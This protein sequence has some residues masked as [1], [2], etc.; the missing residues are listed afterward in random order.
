MNITLFFL[1]N[2]AELGEGQV[3][4][5][6]ALINSNPRS[7]TVISGAKTYWATLDKHQFR[8]IL[9]KH[10][11]KRLEAMIEILD[12]FTLFQSFSKIA[13]S[14]I[15]KSVTKVKLNK[16]QYIFREGETLNKPK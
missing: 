1:K 2:S 9:Q 10:E 6:L 8:R 13:K 5:E 3:F 4:G 15:L 7:A 11:K 16:G 12:S 14:K